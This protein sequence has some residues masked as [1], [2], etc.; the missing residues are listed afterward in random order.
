[1]ASSPK[2]TTVAACRVAG[3]DRDRFNEHVAAG[4]FPCAP[5]TSQGRGRLFDPDNMLALALFSELLKDGLAAH[6]AGPIACEVAA[7]AKRHPD[8]RAISY[9]RAHTV[10]SGWML[11]RTAIPSD[12][13]P[14]PST[15]NKH[16]VHGNLI[17]RVSTFN[18]WQLRQRIAQRTEEERSIIGEEG[19]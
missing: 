2:L 8:A 12:Q 7:A 9:I 5:D 18:V 14:D 10:E 1:M 15:W 11:D 16:L 4:R 6:L 3:I 19:R 17:E 13:V